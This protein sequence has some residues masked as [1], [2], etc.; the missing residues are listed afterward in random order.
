MATITGSVVSNNTAGQRRG[1]FLQLL[2]RP[3]GIDHYRHTI[4]NNTGYSG[5]GLELQFSTATITGST[6]SNTHDGGSNTSLAYGGAISAFGAVSL[7]IAGSLFK[8]NSAIAGGQ[9]GFSLGGAIY[10]TNNGIHPSGSLVISSSTFVGN[11]AIG[12]AAY[13]N[14]TGGAVDVDP[15]TNLTVTGSSFTDNL[16]SGGLDVQGGAVAVQTLFGNQATISSSTFQGNVAIVPAS[17]SSSAGSANGGAL[18]GDGPV[19][20][21]SGTFIANQAIG[22][23]GGGLGGGGAIEDQGGS[24]SLSNSLLISNSAIGAHKAAALGG[25]IFLLTSSGTFNDTV[26]IGNEALG[27]AASGA[28]NQAGV[29]IGGAI[30]SIRRLLALSDCMVASN[31]AIG[32]P[33]TDG[34]LPSFA[35][36]GGINNG[37][38]MTVTDSA[39]IGNEAIG[40]AGGGSAIGGGVYSSGTMTLNDTL[41]TLNQAKGGAGGG[42]GVGGG[43]FLT[44]GVTTILS[45][46]TLVVLNAATTSNNNIYGTYST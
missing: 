15:G 31:E 10:T 29:G 11:S 20:V 45:G 35:V 19:I 4:S 38:S 39:I 21:N 7:N 44:T 37:G 18:F 2:A 12:T 1:Y 9:F 32:G 30:E 27:S 40:G 16:A 6:F 46:T 34:A 13:A 36:G 3:G 14:A 23:P 28:G 17:A 22:G 41:V 25:A 43:L 5:G 26:L 33:A 8:G 42:Q 24:L